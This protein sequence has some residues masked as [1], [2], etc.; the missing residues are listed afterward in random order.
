VTRPLSVELPGI[1]RAAKSPM[2]CENDE[3]HD[4]KRR[5]TTYGYARGVDGVNTTELPRA[6]TRT[7]AAQVVKRATAPAP[8]GLAAWP[9]ATAR[10]GTVGATLA[11]AGSRRQGGRRY[12]AA[13]SGKRVTPG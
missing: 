10:C 1:E 5:E 9:S 13:E 7:R 4:A 3:I 11:R 8:N 2:S 12:A 6:G